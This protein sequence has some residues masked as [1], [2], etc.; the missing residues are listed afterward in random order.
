MPTRLKGST[1]QTLQGE[2]TFFVKLGRGI[3]NRLYHGK[4]ERRGRDGTAV[5][6]PQVLCPQLHTSGRLKGGLKGLSQTRPGA[7]GPG[8]RESAGLR[9]CSGRETTPQ[10]GRSS[11]A[12]SHTPLVVQSTKGQKDPETVTATGAGGRKTGRVWCPGSPPGRK[13]DA[14]RTWRR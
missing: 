8:V 10:E 11:K 1:S 5:G 4:E 7:A 13:S 9:G 3:R 6:P 12:P 14:R 2:R